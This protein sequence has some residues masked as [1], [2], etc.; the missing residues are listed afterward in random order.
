MPPSR[1]K[2]RCR[3]RPISRASARPT[4]ATCWTIRRCIARVE[5]S[6]AAPTAGLH[7]T[8]VSVRGAG[9]ARR[10]PRERDAA[11]RAGHVPAGQRRR[12][13]PAQDACR[14]GP[15]SDGGRGGAAQRGA[16]GAEGASW[17]SARLPCARWKARRRRTARI[18]PFAG[19]TDI[20]ITPGYRFRTAEVLL[21]NFHLPRST[22]FMLVSAFCGLE[23]MKRAYAEAI[24]ERYRFYSYGDACLLFRRPHERIPFRASG[25]RTARRARARS[26]RRAA[27]FARPPSCRSA[28]R[29]TVKAMLP[30][31]V[32]ET[33]AD[34]ILGNTYHLMLRP[35]AERIARLGG[36][37]KFMGW[38]RPI[39]T[40]SGGF[41]VMSLSKLRKITEE[42]VRFRSHIDGTR[43]I[44]LA[45]ARDG[46]PAPARFRHPD[47]A[48][49]MSRPSGASEAEIEKSLALSMRWA[50]RSK[51]AFGEQP[52]RACFGIVQGGVFPHLR[53]RSAHELRR[54]A[55]TAMPWAGWRWARARAAMFDTL[56]ATV[57]HLPADQAALSDGRR[58]AGR[59]RGRGAA[60]HRHVRL[61]AA[62][63]L[64]PQRPGVHLERHAQSA[65]CPPRRRS[66]AARSGL[67]LSRLP[68]V[69]PRLSASCGEGERDHRLDAADLAQSAPSI[70]T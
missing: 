4:S 33:G 53:A 10:G 52:G 31:S 50:K 37:H 55:S 32:R 1:P 13:G 34:I 48:G 69:Q 43:G 40:D 56:E 30:Q 35:G 61:R 26:I 49:R 60:R 57:P 11:C 7:F 59:Y 3:C 28:R 17:R 8:P 63:A 20:F 12:Y 65:Q 67:P 9:G 27:T 29:R 15:S 21:T 58:Q 19:E 2:A 14:N 70:R 54:S 38:E 41:Q 6:V 44:S 16:R 24:R 25:D 5:G 62:D 45:R 68:P 39:L 22:L 66:G 46:D 47:G 23:T 18:A 51:A 36:L 42:G 64:G